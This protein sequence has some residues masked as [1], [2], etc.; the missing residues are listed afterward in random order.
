MLEK[1][2]NAVDK[3]K[4]FGALLTNLSKVFDCLPYELI[5]AKLNAYGFKLP[6]LKL[7]HSYLSHRKQRTKI[8][9][10]YSLWDGILFGVP[11]GSI[12]GPILFNI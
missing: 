5:I 2:K 3:G 12:L 4:V 6:A 1:L 8:N 10:A 11:Q 9:H 7:M